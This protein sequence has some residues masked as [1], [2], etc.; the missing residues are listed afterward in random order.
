MITGKKPYDNLIVC[1]TS[2]DRVH[3]LL[4]LYFSGLNMMVGIM[5]K[6]Q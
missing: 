5:N 6:E 1:Y 3:R 2:G 4:V